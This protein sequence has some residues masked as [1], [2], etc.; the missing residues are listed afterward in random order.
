[1]KAF[2]QQKNLKNSAAP[3]LGLELT[4]H[5]IKSQIHL[6]KQ[7]FSVRIDGAAAAQ[8]QHHRRRVLC[9]ALEGHQESHHR[10][11]PPW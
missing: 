3:F 11:P 8:V 9:E 7:S 4:I 5:V 10:P 6:V 1:M 2:E